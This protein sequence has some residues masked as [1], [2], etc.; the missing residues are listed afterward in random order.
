MASAAATEVNIDACRQDGVSIYRRSSGG[1]T[2]VTGPGC[3]MY[4]LV[5]DFRNQPQLQAIDAAHRFVLGQLAGLLTPLVES[6]EI[7]GTSDLV[8]ERAAREPTAPPR[9]FSGNA[10][11]CKRRHI[12]YH[13]TLLYDFDL[14]RIHRWLA[15]PTRT[16]A[17]RRDRQHKEFLTNLTIGRAELAAAL[18]EGWQAYDALP[19]WPQQR[20]SQLVRSKYTDDPQW[21]VLAPST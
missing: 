17:Y 12:L 13:G 4:A 9:K 6:V 14:D 8:I 16:P 10:M 15:A 18:T 19:R 11:R 3:L 5:L 7:A 1:G 21:V 20:T 2:V